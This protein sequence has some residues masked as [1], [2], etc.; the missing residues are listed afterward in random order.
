MNISVKEDR[1]KYFVVRLEIE[2]NELVMASKY[3]ILVLLIKGVKENPIFE[4]YQASSKEAY[5]AYNAA[6]NLFID[7]ENW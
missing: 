1:D 6:V 7:N 4:E 5:D 2:P 3:R